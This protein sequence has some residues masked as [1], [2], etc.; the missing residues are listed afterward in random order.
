MR[1]WSRLCRRPYVRS[2][3]GV[4]CTDK[5]RSVFERGVPS[6]AVVVQVR[7]RDARKAELVERR[8][9][10]RGFAVDVADRT[11]PRRNRRDPWIEGG[12]LERM[13]GLGRTEE[14]ILPLSRSAFGATTKPI[15]VPVPGNHILKRK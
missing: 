9:A 4:I 2:R 11:R 14:R 5:C 3:T 15:Y 7:D 12:N 10:G 8:L 13:R 1:A 6:R